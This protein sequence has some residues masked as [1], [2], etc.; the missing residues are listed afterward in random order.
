MAGVLQLH[1]LCK[2]EKEFGRIRNSLVINMLIVF[3]CHKHKMMFQFYTNLYGVWVTGL[4]QD[5]Q[6]S[7]IRN[8]EESGKHQALLFQIAEQETV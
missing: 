6:Q 4:S 3:F 2:Q 5:F 8:K 1:N 7:G